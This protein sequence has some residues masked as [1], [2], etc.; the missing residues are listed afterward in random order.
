MRFTRSGVKDWNTGNDCERI[1]VMK[2]AGSVV[3]FCCFIW[4]GGGLSAVEFIPGQ[5]VALPFERL[6]KPLIVYL[7]ENYNAAKRW[8]RAARPRTLVTLWPI[9]TP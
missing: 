2:V 5:E 4:W 9:I 1:N 6:V 7:P 8:P 3:V